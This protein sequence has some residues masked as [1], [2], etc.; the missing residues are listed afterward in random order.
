MAPHH[1]RRSRA[2]RSIRAASS[3]TRRSR[4]RPCAPWSR[5]SPPPP[6]SFFPAPISMSSPMAAPRP[7]WRSARRRCSSTSASVRPDVEC[8]TPITAAFAAFRAFGAR[9][10]G[11]LTPYRADVNRIVADYIRARGFEVP[12]FGSFNEENDSIVAAHH[13][14]HRS[15]QGITAIRE[16]GR[17]RC[18]LRLLHVGAPRRSRR[19]DRGGDRPSGHLVQSRDGLACAAARRRRRQAC[20]N[21]AAVHAADRRCDGS[22]DCRGIGLLVT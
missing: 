9:R 15:R 18:G 12:V 10:I 16:Q 11:V 7:R 6:M 13:A 1:D 3:T 14:R 5:A 17:D 20:R 21:G 4:P 2:S 22:R 8:T 19:R